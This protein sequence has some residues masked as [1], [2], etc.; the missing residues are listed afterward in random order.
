MSDPKE[1]RDFTKTKAYAWIDLASKIVSSVALVALGVAG[2][3]LQSQAE[4]TRVATQQFELQ[5]RRYLPMLRSLSA[6]EVGL[7]NIIVVSGEGLKKQTQHRLTASA[8]MRFLSGS[9]FEPDG[10]R[11][12]LFHSFEA[13]QEGFPGKEK[14]DARIKLPLRA[15]AFMYADLLTIQ[16]SFAA[17]TSGPRPQVLHLPLV[18]D[19]RSEYLVTKDHEQL[20]E[21]DYF[22]ISPEAGPAWK[23]WLANN[24]LDDQFF[25][26]R[27][28]GKLGEDLRYAV[29]EATREVLSAHPDL[30][31]RYV[32]IR[33]E[34][35]KRRLPNP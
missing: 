13:L 8:E 3:M 17:M 29:A 6:L 10:D 11:E 25:L 16:N 12:K 14:G 34:I 1:P 33:E 32:Q 15:A 23:I 31:D 4:K 27:T 7:E 21:W 22:P 18:L 5:E 9:L 26:G 30:G 28:L 24:E 2:W 19:A 35:E 20:E